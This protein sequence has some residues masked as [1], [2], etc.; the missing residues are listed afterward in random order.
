MS[1]SICDSLGL[2]HGLTCTWL[3]RILMALGVVTIQTG[4][5][6]AKMAKS[7]VSGDWPG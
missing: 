2:G 7:A 6:N 5:R 1:H 4:S 3:S